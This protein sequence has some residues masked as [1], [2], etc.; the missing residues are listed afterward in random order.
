MRRPV[1]PARPP[2]AAPTHRG[3]RNGVPSDLRRRAARTAGPGLERAARARTRAGARRTAGST[4]RAHARAV[5]TGRAGGSGRPHVGGVEAAGV[6]RMMR[7]GRSRRPTR[8]RRAATGKSAGRRHGHQEGF[9]SHTQITSFHAIATDDRAGAC[10]ERRTNIKISRSA[11][12]VRFIPN[13][14]DPFLAGGVHGAGRDLGLQ[15]HAIKLIGGA[16]LLAGV[17]LTSGA[18]NQIRT[19]TTRPP[20]E[21]AGSLFRVFCS[22]L[23]PIRRGERENQGSIVRTETASQDYGVRRSA[24]R[25]GVGGC[26]ADDNSAM[27]WP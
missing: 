4:A 9:D 20:G 8:H 17:A 26:V 6:R 24:A 13:A 14:R 1:R 12:R 18:F 19:R 11:G 22:G 5:V 7:R 10:D 21:T 3:G 16:V 2:P 15:L 25:E 23:L 27:R